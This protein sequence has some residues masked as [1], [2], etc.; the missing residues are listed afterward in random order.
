L[1]TATIP[2]VVRAVRGLDRDAGVVDV[3]DGAA[4]YRCDAEPAQRALGLGRQR[5]REPGEHAVGHLDEQDAA[6]ARVRRAEVAA[7]G[8]A[9]S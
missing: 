3:D 9:R 8:R 2:A 5:R 1:T 4:E 7:Q 6:A